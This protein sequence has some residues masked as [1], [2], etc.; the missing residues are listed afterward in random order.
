MNIQPRQGLRSKI[1]LQT[2]LLP[3]T[4]LI[5]KPQCLLGQDIPSNMWDLVTTVGPILEFKIHDTGSVRIMRKHRAL[6]YG[7]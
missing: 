5:L 4:V 7:S 2:F 3:F 1:L 6:G